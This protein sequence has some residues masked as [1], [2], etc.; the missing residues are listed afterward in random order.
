MEI[1]VHFVNLSLNWGNR[2][3]P[4]AIVEAEGLE[5][6]WE[7]TQHIHSDWTDGPK[8][9][10]IL[11]SKALRSSM[12]GDLFETPDGTFVVAGCGFTEWKSPE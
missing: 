3:F 1:K 6:A 11:G 8:V 12:V 5:E 7:A 2:F 4:V 9:K 10:K